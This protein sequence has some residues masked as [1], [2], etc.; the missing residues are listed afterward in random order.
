M[1]AE[2]IGQFHFHLLREKKLALGTI[3]LHIGASRFLYKKI[4]KRRD[5]DFDALP[6]L[7]TPRS[8]PSC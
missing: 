1:G 4:L 6:L 7:K 8:C 5:L 3:A 2:K